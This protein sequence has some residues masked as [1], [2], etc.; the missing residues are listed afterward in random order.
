MLKTVVL[1][2][3]FKYKLTSIYFIYIYNYILSDVIRNVDI[4][5][6]SPEWKDVHELL[7]NSPIPIQ[8]WLDDFTR[9]LR[10]DDRFRGHIR[11]DLSSS[12]ETKLELSLQKWIE[13]ESSDVTWDMIIKTLEKLNMKR[14]A[15][16]VKGYLQH[17]DVY[18]KYS[19]KIDF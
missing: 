9:E 10:L 17:P 5:K 1:H 18:K 2:T 13:S 19:E 8:D 7:K 14:T 12:F 16:D 4:S 15:K 11:N 3:S 6:K